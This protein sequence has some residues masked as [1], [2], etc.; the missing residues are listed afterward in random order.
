MGAEHRD[1]AYMYGHPSIGSFQ[2]PHAYATGYSDRVSVAPQAPLYA[3]DHLYG[4]SAY[5]PYQPYQP[6]AF[7]ED[8]RL[9]PYVPHGPSVLPSPSTAQHNPKG[10]GTVSCPRNKNF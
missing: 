9:P 10:P 6:Y 7:Y 5:Q 1:M 8:P 4:Y 2:P 3:A